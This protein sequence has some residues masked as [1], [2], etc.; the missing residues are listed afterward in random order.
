[1]DGLLNIDK[2]A[3]LSS[4]AVVTRVKRCLPR[5]VKVGHAGTLDPFATGVL[6]ILLGRATKLAEQLMSQP[7]QY[8][9]TVKLGAT[10]TTLDPE[11]SEIPTP[12]AL[13]P[14]RHTI[15][16]LLPRFVG[17]IQQKPPAFSALKVQGKTAYSLARQGLPIELPSRMV[18]VYDIQ[19]SAYNWPCLHLKID[20]GRGTYVRALARDIGQA[21]NVGAYLIR[22]RRTRVGPFFADHALPL[23]DLHPNTISNSI[24]SP[25]TLPL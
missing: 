9:A 7:K 11:S 15:E 2:P 10:T 16:N 8:L 4:A 13:P 5:T 18:T 17:H 12:G 6:V 24:L 14:P 19:I 3:G 1:M 22:L 21:L 20:C 25:D 23:N